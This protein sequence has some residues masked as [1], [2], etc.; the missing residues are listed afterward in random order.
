VARLGGDEFVFVLED[1]GSREDASVV[2]AKIMAALSVPVSLKGNELDIT[3]SIGIALFPDD[4]ND[5]EGV[6]KCADIA[7]YAAKESGRSAFRFFREDI[8][9]VS[10]RPRLG[11]QQFRWAIEAGQL[12]VDYLPQY[13][14]ESGQLIGFE[15]LL[16]WNHPEMGLL[17]P[18]DFMATA[19]DCGMLAVVGEWLIRE[20]CATLHSWQQ[21]GARWLPVTIN[22]AIGQ[23]LGAD[24][25]P[26]IEQVM[27]RYRIPPA[28]LV[29]ELRE[30]AL[31]DATMQGVERMERIGRMGVGLAV[32]D[33]SADRC[34]LSRLQQLPL[35]RLTIK[36]ELFA[37]VPA[38]QKAA[39]LAAAIIGLGH[40]LGLTVLADQVEK[41]AQ[42]DFLRLHGCDQAQGPLLS[43]PLKGE[44]VGPL[45]LSPHSAVDAPPPPVV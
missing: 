23:L 41:D 30:R 4:S 33:F 32:D 1:I 26:L 9:Q 10:Q 25:L 15:S 34:P 44:V 29:L 16:H 27:A 38:D 6:I 17:H 12:S 14:L 42:M 35:T 13:Q 39:T 24:F 28:M 19:D 18:E 2:A 3:T 45:L 21:Q 22:V 31:A 5:I 7:L 11:D 40:A 36:R 37:R 20:V 8:P 43:L